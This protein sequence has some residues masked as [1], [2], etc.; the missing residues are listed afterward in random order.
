MIAVIHIEAKL[1]ALEDLLAEI[2]AEDYETIAQVKGAI[3]SSIESLEGLK[4]KYY[5]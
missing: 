4:G 3:Y 1:Q 5:E 2:E